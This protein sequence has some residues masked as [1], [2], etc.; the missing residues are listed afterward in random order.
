MLHYFFLPLE[1]PKN[2]KIYS[3]LKKDKNQMIF[4]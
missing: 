2:C 3:F 4:Y 1:G